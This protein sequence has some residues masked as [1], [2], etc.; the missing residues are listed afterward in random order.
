MGSLH[1]LH[2]DE[3]E[4]VGSLVQALFAYFSVH[5]LFPDNPSSPIPPTSPA[6]E[7]S[8]LHYWLLRSI[9][10]HAKFAKG[11]RLMSARSGVCDEDH[12][13]SKGIAELRG[14]R[15]WVVKNDQVLHSVF[16]KSGP[17][18]L[19]QHNLSGAKT[20]QFHAPLLFFFFGSLEDERDPTS[21]PAHIM[22]GQAPSV[23]PPERAAENKGPEVL[24]TGWALTA[25]ATL[26]VIA[27]LF[28]RFKKLG[29]IGTGDYI[30]LL[31]L[32]SI[33]SPFNH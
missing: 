13:S 2:G 18:S 26:F 21:T 7:F 4:G 1:C 25:T 3:D 29:K 20:S 10:R 19:E 33:P 8:A 23:P 11:A 9:P 30:V 15:H 28:S 22:S 27:R 17:V 24:I 32:V 14:R 16:G 31:S 6:G 12:L 5:T